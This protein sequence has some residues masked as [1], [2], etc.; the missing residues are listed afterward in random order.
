ML[1]VRAGC[2][3]VLA[4]GDPG[5]VEEMAQGM[6]D[7]TRT[8]PDIILSGVAPSVD[9]MAVSIANRTVYGEMKFCRYAVFPVLL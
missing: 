9:A 3:I 7:R 6:I 5:V 4:S 8:D 1:A 2:D